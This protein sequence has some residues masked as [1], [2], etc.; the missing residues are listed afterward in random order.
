M[1][2]TIIGLYLMTQLLYLTAVIIYTLR[3]YNWHTIASITIYFK[4][5]DFWIGTFTD[6]PNKRIYFQLIPMLGI[7]FDN[8]KY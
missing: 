7:R 1:I 5:Y 8:L 4:W 6:V 2:K 3:K